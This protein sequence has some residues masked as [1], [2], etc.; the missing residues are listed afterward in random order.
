[1]LLIF[2]SGIF[3]LTGLSQTTPKINI[4]QIWAYFHG[5]VSAKIKLI[6]IQICT[7]LC[8]PQPANAAAQLSLMTGETR[9]NAVFYSTALLS[10]MQ[11]KIRGLCIDTLVGKKHELIKLQ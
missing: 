2:H 5:L 4:W 9:C 8:R 3:S 7:V 6:K 10:H 11:V 1:M